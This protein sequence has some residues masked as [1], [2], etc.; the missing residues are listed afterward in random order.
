[1]IAEGP[2]ELVAKVPESATGQFL[3]PLLG[4]KG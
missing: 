4:P 3:A 1:V 2:P